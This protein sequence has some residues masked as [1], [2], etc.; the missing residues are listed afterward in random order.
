MRQPSYNQNYQFEDPFSLLIRFYCLF[1]IVKSDLR[2]TK[3]AAN[4]AFL[5]I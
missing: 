2:R 1:E 3:K 5:T 4:A